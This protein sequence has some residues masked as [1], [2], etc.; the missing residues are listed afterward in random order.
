MTTKFCV[1][2]SPIEHSLSPKLHTA[3]YEFLGLDF[4]Y[5]KHRVPEGE[6]KTFL[7]ANNFAG[8]SVTMPL[9]AEAFALAALRDHLVNKTQV[10]NT[11][12]RTESGW[13]AFNTDIAGIRRSLASIP[14]PAK[15]VLIGA[16]ATTSS[17]LVALAE[18]FPGTNLA[19]MARNPS[20]RESAAVFART[21]GLS[22][23]EAD[24]NA[25][26]LLDADL[27]LSLTPSG[28]LDSLWSEFTALGGNRTGYLF[29]VSY[30][31]WPSQAA[32][33]WGVDRTISGL[34]MLIWQAI[35]QVGL[36]SREVLNW[37]EVDP[38]KLYE[39]MKSAVSSE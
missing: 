35:D 26:K 27:V 19:M 3:A 29:D 38:E 23:T 8:V 34:E 10:A 12:V 14:A 28:S 9:K 17:A 24:I 21:N 36:F 30:A 7:D 1:V 39:V 6:L 2:G 31:P 37:Q 18:L 4:Q 16:G 25:K 22:T 11:L 13:S 32:R 5:S 20:R 15:T 33:A